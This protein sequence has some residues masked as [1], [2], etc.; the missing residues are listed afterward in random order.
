MTRAECLRLLQP[1]TIVTMT[2]HDWYPNGYPV[3]V[4]RVVI[5]RRTRDVQ[6]QGTRPDG[7]VSESW[8]TIAT[9]QDFR[10]N[11]DSTFSVRLDPDG[12]AWMTYRLE[13][14]E[15]AAA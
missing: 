15:V 11:G 4:P 1:G 10:D 14:H 8:M 12:S 6:L 9:A 5:R 13:V 2:G 7:T 3:G